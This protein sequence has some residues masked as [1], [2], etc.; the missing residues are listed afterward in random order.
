MIDPW[1]QTYSSQLYPATLQVS[2][3]Q[4]V[5]RYHRA[6]AVKHHLRSKTETPRKYTTYEHDF[7]FFETPRRPL[8]SRSFNQNTQ[9][10]SSDSRPKSSRLISYC[11]VDY[12]KRN[13]VE[14]RLF[15]NK[16][17][18]INQTIHT[19]LSLRM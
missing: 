2:R 8:T 11:G 12:R 5:T 13:Q 18:Q 6:A 3:I 4:P 17:I 9:E 16:E 14:T 19:W 15:F 1:N 7:S 10:I